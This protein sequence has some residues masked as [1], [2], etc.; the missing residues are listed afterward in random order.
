LIPG[1]ASRILGSQS[2]QLP[3]ARPIVR[4][5]ASAT[6]RKHGRPARAVYLVGS[7]LGNRFLGH[8]LFFLFF[9]LED[10]R[11]FP[12]QLSAPFGSRSKTPFSYLVFLHRFPLV[13]FGGFSPIAKLFFSAPHGARKLSAPTILQF[14]STS[15]T[16]VRRF[17]IDQLSVFLCSSPRGFGGFS[18]IPELVLSV[19]YRAGR[20]SSPRTLRFSSLVFPLG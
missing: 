16:R 2:Q 10:G 6:K 11:F 18:P 5:E 15:P 17:F 19:P 3:V 12:S 1:F 13:G 7:G 4:P 8:L 20:L 14:S 9:L